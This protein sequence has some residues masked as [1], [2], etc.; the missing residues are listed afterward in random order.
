MLTAFRPILLLAGLPLTV[1]RSLSHQLTVSLFLRSGSLLTII[2]G[3]SL[4]GP[5]D[6]LESLGTLL[7]YNTTSYS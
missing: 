3:Y 6:T 2:P 5:E 4:G 1:P 7:A